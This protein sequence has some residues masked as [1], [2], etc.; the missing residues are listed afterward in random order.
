MAE[1]RLLSKNASEAPFFPKTANWRLAPQENFQRHL[2]L[3][4]AKSGNPVP[5]PVGYRNIFY[6]LAQV[7]KVDEHAVH[8]EGHEAVKYDYLLLASGGKPR[9]LE[10]SGHHLNNIVELRSPNDANRIA[11][12]SSHK[13]VI[14]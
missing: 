11:D 3:E 4:S 7:T 12:Q 5:I 8:V 1:L 2:I 6:F 14:F 10:V 13:N 9:K